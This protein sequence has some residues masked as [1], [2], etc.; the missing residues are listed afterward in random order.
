[1]RTIESNEPELIAEYSRL[2]KLMTDNDIDGFIG[3][4]SGQDTLKV[5]VNIDDKF[6]MVK[7]EDTP[8]IGNHPWSVVD[9]YTL[10]PLISVDITGGKSGSYSMRKVLTFKKLLYK[11]MPTEFEFSSKSY[12]NTV[13]FAVTES[14][15]IRVIS[16]E[17]DAPSFC[18]GDEIQWIEEGE[19]LDETMWNKIYQSTFEWKEAGNPH[20]GDYDGN[21]DICLDKP[22]CKLIKDLN[23][24]DI[25]NHAVN[26]L[27]MHNKWRRGDD[28]IEPTDPIELGNAI[29]TVVD[30]VEDKI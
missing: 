3:S 9:V 5:F 4:A 25:I 13:T 7:F 17:C 23:T 21:W 12:K 22:H 27:R 19:V 30:Y 14:G 10:N 2:Y 6:H 1:M 11:N 8:I 16:H 20:D 15:N 18:T 28:K 26:V 24:L 29:D